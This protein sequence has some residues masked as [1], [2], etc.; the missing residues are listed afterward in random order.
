MVN[1][2]HDTSNP[3]P[4][5][6]LRLLPNNQSPGKSQGSASGN[7]ET[8]WFVNVNVAV[9]RLI[10]SLL[11]SRGNVYPISQ[12]YPPTVNVRKC[13]MGTA[14][15]TLPRVRTLKEQGDYQFFSFP[16]YLRNAN[17]Q[18]FFIPSNF[19]PKKFFCPTPW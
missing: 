10:N 1:I 4:E 2:V 18:K 19:S 7:H 16:S 8:V 17:L 13:M 6:G 15:D 9:I 11:L 3:S 5:F 14:T 12:N